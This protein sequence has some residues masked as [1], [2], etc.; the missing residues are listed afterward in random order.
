MRLNREHV[1]KGGAILGVAGTLGWL[2]P[3]PVHSEFPQH[4][5]PLATATS[6]LDHSA[7]AN[8]GRTVPD[9]R[10]A[11]TYDPTPRLQVLA[12]RLIDIANIKTTLLNGNSPQNTI[13][14]I[15]SNPE[16]GTIEFQVHATAKRLD[17][18]ID[19]T[20]VDSISMCVTNNYPPIFGA[21]CYGGETFN[22]ISHGDWQEMSLYADPDLNH[23]HGSLNNPIQ[24]DAALKNMETIIS[25][26]QK[27]A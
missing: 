21:A 11:N 23:T 3:P 10:E 25:P 6:S 8:M 24:F 4:K 1:Q 27:S 9:I 14:F 17:G 22:K 12:G 19:P 18:Q 26:T 15:E 16:V 2:L 5:Q 13:D 7:E 20:T